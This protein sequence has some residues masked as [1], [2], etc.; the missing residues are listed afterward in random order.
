MQSFE[1]IVPVDPAS[2]FMNVR[3]LVDDIGLSIAHQTYQP[4]NFFVERM[5]FWPR[6]VW[7]TKRN[8]IEEYPDDLVVGRLA[9]LHKP[10]NI[11]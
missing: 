9:K 8:L 3:Q 2:S 4:T 7:C 1:V 5:Q 11:A 10:A 6:H